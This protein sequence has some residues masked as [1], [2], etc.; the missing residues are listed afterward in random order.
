[1]IPNLTTTK[2]PHVLMG[3]LIKKYWAKKQG[4]KEKNVVVVSIMPCTAKKYEIK[5]KQVRVDG[6]APVDYVLTTRE[7]AYMIKRKGI[8]LSKVKPEKADNPLGV[9]SGAGVIYGA[10]GGVT[11]SA[12]RT[13]YK[14]MTGK[15]LKK[16]DFKQIRGD[17]GCKEA[18][19]KINGRKI[20]IAVVNGMENAHNLVKLIKKY[21]NKYHFIEVMSCFGGCIGGGGQPV[22]TD[23]DIRRKR[24]KALYTIDSKNKT[25]V[26]HENPI[27]DIIYKEFLTNKKIRHK[28]AHT[29][30]SK[31]KKENNF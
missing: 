8:D 29:H 4:I 20:K 22:P 3:G 26:A 5:R 15:N 28:I 27:L 18:E 10:S 19:V 30:Y 24:I 17:A 6:T 31:K 11:E 12:L 13:A 14:I 2:S 7:L 23:E 21:P 9:P 25:R 1:L 16:L